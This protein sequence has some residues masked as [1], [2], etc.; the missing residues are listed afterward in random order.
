MHGI[1]YVWYF[2]GDRSHHSRD[3]MW[4]LLIIRGFII[5]ILTLIGSIQRTG[6]VMADEAGY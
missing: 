1:S 4:C 3:V 5:N 2:S 6:I